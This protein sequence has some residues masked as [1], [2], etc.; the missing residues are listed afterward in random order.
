[1]TRL[2]WAVVGERFYETG[3][4]RGV[5]YINDGGYAWSGLASVEESSSGGEPKPYYIDGIK[6]LNLSAKEDF[7]ATIDA[8]YSPPEFD[9]C[10]GF[11]V[12]APGL[13]ASQQRR[14]EFGF[15]YRTKI[16]NDL[17]GSDHAYKIHIIYNALAK[18]TQRT[19]ST[20]ADSPEA[21]LLSWAITT[22][23]ISIPGVAP[24]AHLT[25][26]TTKASPYSLEVLEKVLYGDDSNEPRLPDPDELVS[27]FADAAPLVVTD[28]G[29][30]MFSISGPDLAIQD[31]EDGSY[32]IRSHTV[33]LSEESATISS[34]E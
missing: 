5:L 32:R 15:C 21:P 12:V 31:L 29:D 18:P 26:D 10:D 20:I 34:A 22:K 16:G 1:M 33:E 30:D 9:E 24:S 11:G 23:P 13:F 17:D 6:Y 3:V 14:K 19:Y 7:E 27:L 8:L 28:L 25:I 2:A 4:D